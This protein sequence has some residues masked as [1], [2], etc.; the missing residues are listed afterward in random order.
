MTNELVSIVIPTKNSG[1]FLD[2]CLKSIR[3][4]SYKNIEI[5]IVDGN[6]KDNTLPAAKKY[7]ARV[8]QYDPGLPKGTFDAPPRR[9]YGMMKAK[10]K[11]VYFSDADYELSKN[12]IKDCVA[13]C[14][15]GAVAVTTPLDTFGEGI[16]T[17]AKNLERR[18]YFG[19]DSV[20]CP[21]FFRTDVLREVGGF[22]VSLGA[23]GD[24]WDLYL[25]VREKYPKVA[26]INT[27]VMHNEG[28]IKLSKL[29]KKSIMYGKDALKYLDKRPKDAIRSFFP[30]R[31]GYLKNWRLFV[32]RP[33]D[34]I[35]LIIVRFTEYLGGAIGVLK[36]LQEPRPQRN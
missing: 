17:R 15:K 24:D 18:C 36:S 23:G 19:D 30:I 3:N 22:D 32:Q 21:R 7:K 31:K 4:Q 16:W 11:Y 8:L 10:G 1:I 9:N 27:V 5:I 2:N 14:K 12:V 6:S 20:E 29:F 26:R 25:K 34:T 28:R 33:V 13:C 35:A